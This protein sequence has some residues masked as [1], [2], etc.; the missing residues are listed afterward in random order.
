MNKGYI[1]GLVNPNLDACGN[2]TEQVQF[3]YWVGGGLW[4]SLLA[5]PERLILLFG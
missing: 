3:T 2:I 5:H 1:K 4:S